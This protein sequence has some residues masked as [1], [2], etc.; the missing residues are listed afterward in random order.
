VRECGEYG[1]RFGGEWNGG[2]LNNS[3][4]VIFGGFLFKLFKIIESVN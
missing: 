2:N 1:K 3:S 4:I